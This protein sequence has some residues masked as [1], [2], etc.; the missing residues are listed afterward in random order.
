MAHHAYHA[1]VR[2]G[3]KKRLATLVGRECGTPRARCSCHARMQGEAHAAR[4][5]GR[6]LLASAAVPGGAGDF[7]GGPGGESGRCQQPSHAGTRRPQGRLRQEQADPRRSLRAGTRRP[8]KVECTCTMRT[9]LMHAMQTR[10][11]SSPDDVCSQAIRDRPR[12]ED[13]NREHLKGIELCHQHVM[14]AP[15]HAQHSTRS[16]ACNST[17]HAHG[18]SLAYCS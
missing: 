2:Q 7:W 4:R 15:Q 14:C 8:Q 10:W 11:Q 18:N 3:C 13:M 6:W 16:T 5:Q 1:H 17:Q 12:A 9:M